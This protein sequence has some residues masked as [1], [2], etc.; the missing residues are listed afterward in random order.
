[1]RFYLHEMSTVQVEQALKKTDTVIIPLGNLEAHGPHEPVGTCL[2]LADTAAKAVG[3][4]TGVPVTP[5]FPVGISH[6][7]SNFP[8][9]MNVRPETFAHMIKEMSLSLIHHGF[10]RIIYFSAHG[11][12]NLTALGHVAEELRDETGVLCAVL[13]LWGLVS[14]VSPKLAAPEGV[15]GGHGG[16]PETSVML[17]LRPE[18]VDMN[19]ANLMPLKTPLDGF[20][21][22][23]HSS[24]LFRG[25]TVTIPLSGEE[26]SPTAVYADPSRASAERG[27]QL[28]QN[29]VDYLVQ[30]VENF[31]TMRIP[32]PPK[33]TGQPL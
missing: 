17:H 5:T 31:R 30:F 22:N 12:G 24:H 13:H 27:R 20:T 18:L 8:G 3:E 25:G 19:K 26:V 16:E 21:T 2:I 11:G 14:Q 10:K 29:L 7:Y 33:K 6:A 9:S 28:Y 1:M 32:Q 15:R 4:R 23:S